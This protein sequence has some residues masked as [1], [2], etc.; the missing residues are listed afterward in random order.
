MGNSKSKT[1]TNFN[2]VPLENLKINHLENEI[3][4]LKTHITYLENNVKLL[5]N[6]F[7]NINTFNYNKSLFIAFIKTT[8]QA[9]PN[10]GERYVFPTGILFLIEMFDFNNF[11]KEIIENLKKYNKFYYNKLNINEKNEFFEFLIKILIFM[12]KSK[13]I[14][15]FAQLY[16]FRD[17]INSIIDPFKNPDK[18]YEEIRMYLHNELYK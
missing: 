2:E 12:F 5:Q 3:S 4:S 10:K 1:K 11:T 9:M 14:T 7:E 17:D 18:D 15:N 16:I 6:N 13:E 8:V